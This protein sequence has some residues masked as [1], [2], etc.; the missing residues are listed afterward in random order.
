VVT[1]KLVTVLL[2]GVGKCVAEASI[3][4]YVPFVGSGIAAAIGF[5]AMQLVGKL[6][7]DNCYRTAKTLL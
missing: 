4:K 7:I 1:K 5:G 2:R 6:H 3:A